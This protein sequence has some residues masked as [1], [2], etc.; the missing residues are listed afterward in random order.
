MFARHRTKEKSVVLFD[1][2]IK[3]YIHVNNSEQYKY[4]NNSKQGNSVYNWKH[5]S[6]SGDSSKTIYR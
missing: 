4:K 2:Y 5:K 6:V 3:Q 1:Q